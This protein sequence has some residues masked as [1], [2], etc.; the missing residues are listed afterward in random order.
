VGGGQ[1]CAVDGQVGGRV[2][3]AGGQAGGR[4]E[5]E[6]ASS[7]VIGAD[8]RRGLPASPVLPALLEGFRQLGFTCCELADLRAGCTGERRHEGAVARGDRWA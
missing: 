3:A 6:S 4:V 2:G 8:W 1:L 7:Q 5:G